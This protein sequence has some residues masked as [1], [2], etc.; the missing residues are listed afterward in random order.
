M[1]KIEPGDIVI[2]RT[3]GE[4]IVVYE[5]PFTDDFSFV[6]ESFGRTVELL[7]VVI[8]E[9][10]NVDYNLTFFHVVMPHCVG[11]IASVHVYASV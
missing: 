8:D 3:S 1:K 10:H 7:G 5:S 11:W 2:I 9:H 6:W 4:E